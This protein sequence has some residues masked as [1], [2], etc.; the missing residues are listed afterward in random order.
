MCLSM[1]RPRSIY[2]LS[3]S[4]VFHFQPHSLPLIIV[5]HENRCNCFLHMFQNI[6]YYFWMITWM[7]KAN[8]FLI[9]KVQP[10]G[11]A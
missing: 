10:Q 2:V 9:A 11:V 4:S 6:S 3:I 1:S 8:N 5:S 7:K